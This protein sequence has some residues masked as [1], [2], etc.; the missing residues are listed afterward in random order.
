[1]LAM[2]P[3]HTTRKS[4][5]K[6]VIAEGRV[7]TDSDSDRDFEVGL[8]VNTAGRTTTTYSAHITPTKTPKR[9]KLAAPSATHSTIEATSAMTE[10]A[11]GKAKRKQVCCVM[12]LETF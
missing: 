2:S 9:K 8:L 5:R 6:R 7:D 12:A 10:P 3:L 11:P 4:K 1:M